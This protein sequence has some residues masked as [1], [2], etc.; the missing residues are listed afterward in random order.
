M[1]TVE[2]QAQSL[3]EQCREKQEQLG[4]ADQIEEW[5]MRQLLRRL[6]VQSELNRRYKL[7]ARRVAL[8]ARQVEEAELAAL[9]SEVESREAAIRRRCDVFSMMERLSP[10]AAAATQ[11]RTAFSAAAA[12]AAGCA[13]PGAGTCCRI[14]RQ[15]QGRQP[16]RR[17]AV[18]VL[19]RSTLCVAQELQVR[20][21]ICVGAAGHP[22][23]GGRPRRTQVQ[24]L[25][26]FWF[27]LFQRAQCLRRWSS[28]NRFI[29]WQLGM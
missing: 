23:A 14:Q 19:R 1:Y 29:A 28:G 4:R 25:G 2:K 17:K 11:S 20:R 3:G 5:R 26:S 6:E 12:A 22:V 10:R 9:A 8:R 24:W 7:E 27:C 13:L 16:H 18:Q 15:R 21:A